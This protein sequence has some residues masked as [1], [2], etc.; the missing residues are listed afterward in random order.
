MTLLLPIY[1]S[2]FVTR[3]PG[4]G[5]AGQARWQDAGE[6]FARALNLVR[7]GS[8]LHAP[9]PIARVIGGNDRPTGVSFTALLLIGIGA[10]SAMLARHHA[11]GRDR[12]G[13][14]HAVFWAIVGTLISTPA[15]SFFGDT[16]VRSPHFVLSGWLFPWLFEI[17][18]SPT[19]LGI[20]A[21]M[22][23]S[24]L[25]GL[26]FSECANRVRTL[27]RVAA[28][29][30][31]LLVLGCSYAEWRRDTPS[32]Y[33]LSEALR[34]DSPIVEALRREDGPVLEL[35]IH[36][37]LESIQHAKAMYRSIFHWR[38]VLNGYTRFQP[39]GFVARMSL[40]NRLPQPD[41]LEALRRETGLA[42]ILVRAAPDTPNL[43]AWLAFA[44]SGGD[45]PLTLVARD[46]RD[47]LFRVAR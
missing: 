32:R 31:A 24:L 43:S 4:A 39:K 23:L 2:H 6:P 40:A 42:A 17:V 16:A 47:L 12:V 3:P 13:W 30:L 38:P 26:A 9:L 35:P 19:R 27:G 1:A 10:I 28:P 41:A 7:I 37:A 36:G 45:G 14:K 44:A 5:R 22:G 25:A 34:S 29:L 46:G 11:R 33:P 8:T 18:R 20:A 15:V 21:L